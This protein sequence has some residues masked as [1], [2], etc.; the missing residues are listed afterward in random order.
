MRC[1]GLDPA[2]YSGYSLR[3]GGVTAML[4]SAPLPAVKRHVGWV[5]NSNAIFAY[6]DHRGRAAMRLATNNIN[7]E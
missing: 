7:I 2:F 5:P 3:R 6:F 4:A 1:A